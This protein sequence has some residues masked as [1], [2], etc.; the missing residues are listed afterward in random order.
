MTI[1]HTFVYLSKMFDLPIDI[2]ES[3]QELNKIRDENQNKEV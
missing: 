2:I 1:Q 3:L